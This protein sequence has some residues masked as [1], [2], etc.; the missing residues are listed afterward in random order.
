MDSSIHTYDDAGSTDTRYN[1]VDT[2]T[3]KPLR[4]DVILPFTYTKD[5][6]PSS[7]RRNTRSR[8]EHTS[9][10][11]LFIAETIAWEPHCRNLSEHYHTSLLVWEYKNRLLSPSKQYKALKEK[12]V[13]WQVG[14]EIHHQTWDAAYRILASSREKYDRLNT[15]WHGLVESHEALKERYSELEDWY[16]AL[17]PRYRDLVKMYDE[18]SMMHDT[19]KTQYH[20]D[21]GFYKAMVDRLQTTHLE[22]ELPS[23]R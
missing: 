21:I 4:F 22:D 9:H 13:G 7:L 19:L 8:D 6:N 3:E 10:F 17:S 18:L 16:D 20:E 11:D 14:Y 5:H 15:L 12:L 23:Q 2:S 1:N